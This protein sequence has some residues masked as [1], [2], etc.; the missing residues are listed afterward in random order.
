MHLRIECIIWLKLK[1]SK[2]FLDSHHS[3]L[4]KFPTENKFST[5]NPFR[6]SKD[7]IPQAQACLAL[8][9]MVCLFC[10]LQKSSGSGKGQVSMHNL[11]QNKRE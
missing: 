6:K 8:F 5:F 10:N 3:G 1:T 11:K 7:K 4:T 2:N 9:L